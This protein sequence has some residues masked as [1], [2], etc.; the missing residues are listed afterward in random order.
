M[1][2]R[3]WI[4]SAERPLQ[5]T[6]RYGKGCYWEM[7]HYLMEYEPKVS[8]NQRLKLSLQGLNRTN[9]LTFKVPAV[10]RPLQVQNKPTD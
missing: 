7:A 4:K 1:H 6:G 8:Q 3:P 10:G 5:L 9:G 2:T